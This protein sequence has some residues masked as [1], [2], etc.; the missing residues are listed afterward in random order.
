MIEI[1][2]L[3]FSYEG[4][5]GACLQDVS[6]SVKSGEV[7]VV[8]G[9]SGSGKT[10]LIRALNG[11][12]PHYYEGYMTGSVSVG[13]QTLSS[14][15]MPA[16]ARMVG[17]VFQNPRSQFFNTDTVTEIAFGLENLGMPTEEIRRRVERVVVDLDIETLMGKSVFELS[18]GEKQI[19]AIAAAY[20][21]GPDVFVMDEPSANLDFDA[22]RR[23][24]RLVERLK[25]R[26]KT[27]VVSEHR[28]YYLKDAVDRCVY[29]QDG[30]VSHEFSRD[31]YLA[32][33][34]GDQ[35]ALG[36]RSLDLSLV[37]AQV[38]TAQPEHDSQTGAPLR[39][40]GLRGGYRRR[41]TL[42]GV[43]IE[44]P[45]GRTV[46][47]LGKNGAGKSTLASVLCGLVRE[48]AGL[49]SVG[50]ELSFRRRAGRF[51]LIMQDA[52]SQLFSDTVAGELAMS[53]AK[54]SLTVKATAALLEEL[55]LGGTL[56]RH[57]LSLSGG[58]KQRLAI[59]TAI[60]AEPDVVILDEPTSGLDF[61]NMQR[62]AQ[63][64][65]RLARRGTRV[66]VITHDY[67][68][69]CRM[70]DDIAVLESGR[71]TCTYPLDTEHAALLRAWFSIG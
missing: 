48:R 28:V 14:L 41:E 50:R 5:D 63:A 64:I 47:L 26:G 56:S 69:I 59:A 37:E 17:S 67:E 25:E 62:I 42:C 70:A 35:A 34:S 9:R 32:L 29:L 60:V 18:G 30:R 16:I 55:G 1:S 36:L 13:G 66:L 39:V 31:G 52:G 61:V 51:F 57:P 20:A 45:A 54:G 22:T 40:E 10:T 19:V 15:P 11:L 7:V 12:I 3:G 21:L 4:G 38:A 27:V 49:V 6:L 24:G 2:N 58:E 33:S 68:F 43:D 46:C 8:T 71:V 23:L 44:V 65:R 53:D